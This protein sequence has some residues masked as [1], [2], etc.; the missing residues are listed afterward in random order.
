VAK[1]GNAAQ[2]L[3]HHAVNRDMLQHIVG[4]QENAEDDAS[5]TISTAS[6]EPAAS[7]RFPS[8]CL[9]FERIQRTGTIHGAQSSLHAFTAF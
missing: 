2:R 4:L 7:A 6:K 3:A 9:N 5:R 1:N 8:Q